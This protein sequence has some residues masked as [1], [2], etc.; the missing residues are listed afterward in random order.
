M[1]TINNNNN[2]YNS[3]NSNKDVKI[4]GVKIHF[5]V[6]I[7]FTIGLS[8]LILGYAYIY[9]KSSVLEI[10]NLVK[11]YNNNIQKNV[12]QW[13]ASANNSLSTISIVMTY[14]FNDNAN[15]SDEKIRSFLNSYVDKSNEIEALYFLKDDTKN[16]LD[17]FSIGNKTILSNSSLFISEEKWENI[18]SWGKSAVKEDGVFFCGIYESSKNMQNKDSVIILA[19][20]V[21]IADKVVGIIFAEF[22]TNAFV[23]A[24]KKDK[25]TLDSESYIIAQDKTLITDRKILLSDKEFLLQR[26]ERFV[27]NDTTKDF[28]KRS[29]VGNY[30]I[31]RNNV[32]NYPWYI[33]TIGKNHDLTESFQKFWHY[34]FY[35]CFFIYIFVIFFILYY[36]SQPFKSF[37]F[38]IKTSL[39]KG[40][41]AVEQN[42]SNIYEINIIAHY[43]KEFNNKLNLFFI[44]VQQYLV[45]QDNKDKN[46]NSFLETLRESIDSII[47]IGRNIHS[48][49]KKNN[50]IRA[51]SNH[52]PASM[53]EKVL[54]LNDF[55][56]NE[57]KD[58]HSN[59]HVFNV[60]VDNNFNRK[61]MLILTGE[62]LQILTNNYNIGKNLLEESQEQVRDIITHTNSVNETNQVI[63]DMITRCNLLSMNAVI[64]AFH[65]GEAGKGF[66]TLANE[67]RNILVS[68]ADY[69]KNNESSFNRTQ[70][71][72]HNY[73]S[74]N[75]KIN[76]NIGDVYIGSN[77]I[78][79]KFKNISDLFDEKF[80]NS[81]DIMA[82][83]QKMEIMYSHLKEQVYVFSKLNEEN[84]KYIDS[85]KEN[86]QKFNFSMQ[87]FY[88][89]IISFTNYI[90]DNNQYRENF[91]KQSEQLVE[92]LNKFRNKNS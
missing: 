39:K 60:F 47:S 21:E 14:Y 24:V 70:D 25:I 43:L 82:I 49:F 31:V 52:I 73:M 61:E 58:I 22:K 40:I 57:L 35:I 91:S 18:A 67:I 53:N 64:E 48:D 84:Q 33:I 30:F 75:Q 5:T 1:S 56:N 79:G 37:I 71:L 55:L 45:A 66:V 7:M 13:F 85:M 46:I 42:E 41:L 76:E 23:N 62:T 16:K 81:E 83:L 10:E 90:D 8:F 4:T 26:D 74:V 77:E 12:K 80:S 38:S 20:K 15:I 72:I 17:I 28:F 27:Y 63:I 89:N 3:Y 78:Y 51:L 6:V 32:E 92:A 2:S 19:K 36:I 44:S 68:I 88:Q 34:L 11:Y 87:N 65:M 29:I 54:A 9:R 50:E 69:L 59:M 86:D